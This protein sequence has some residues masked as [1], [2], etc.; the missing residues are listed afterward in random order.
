MTPRCA[1]GLAAALL[2]L[3]LVLASPSGVLAT[4]SASAASYGPAGGVYAGRSSQRHP[5]SLA[6]TRDGKR[7]KRLLVRVEA[8]T[9]T[10][11]PKTSYEQTL[12]FDPAK[13]GKDGRFAEAAPV[14]GATQVGDKVLHFQ[15]SVKGRLGGTRA[16]GKLRLSGNVT[17]SAGNV[18]DYCDS[19][20]VPW[21][22]RRGGVY[23]GATPQG[24][25]VAIRLSRNRKQ[26][27]SFFIDFQVK[28]GSS[29]FLYSLEHRHI[30]VRRGGRVVKRG[31]S[32]LP[33]K[34]PQGASVTGQFSL[35]GRLGPTKASGAYRAFGT[36][37]QPDGTKLKC[38]TGRIKWSARRG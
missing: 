13:V 4:Q 20:A 11:S 24:G 16:H 10:S 34:T 37:L 8:S 23:G 36:L 15:A 5:L 6:L 32:G 3:P 31:V 18:V 9:C 7:L 1:V 38:N 27:S 12:E 19:G 25:A 14:T 2:A 30:S 26:I 28:C 33:I 35:R 17:D 22:L 21:K 29:T